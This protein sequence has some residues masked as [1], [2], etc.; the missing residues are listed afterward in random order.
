MPFSRRELFNNAG[1]G[2]LLLPALLR[3]PQTILRHLLFDPE[4]PLVSP[5]PIP[6]NPLM[7]EGR[8]LVAIVYG[9]EP[10]RMLRRALELLGG[11]DRLGLRGHRVLLKPNVLNDQPPPSTTNPLVVKAMAEMVR[12]NGAAEVIVAD[13]SGVRLAATDLTLAVTA[14]CKADV[15]KGGTVALPARHVFDVV[16]VLPDGDVTVTVEKNFSARIKSG[17]RR[18]DLRFRR[19]RI[20]RKQGGC[21]H[22]HAGRADAALRSAVAQKRGLKAVDAVAR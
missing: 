19:A 20:D 7:R 6:I 8:S 5:K 11:I 10:G 1:F 18:F 2:L 15:R 21:R 4:G 22:Q 14:H 13:G 16:K 3:S 17:K 9:T 12:A